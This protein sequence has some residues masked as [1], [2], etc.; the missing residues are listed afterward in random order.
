M[1]WA[2]AFAPAT[3]TCDVIKA[4]EAAPLLMRDFDGALGGSF[5]SRVACNDL[6]CRTERFAGGCG[7][8]FVASEA[9]SMATCG[10]DR[11]GGGK[12][13]AGGA[14]DDYDDFVLQ[15]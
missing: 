9:N 8:L 4:I 15:K 14:A 11:T 1:Q 2:I 5:F 12:S 6:R 13:E 3:S 10:D 7:A